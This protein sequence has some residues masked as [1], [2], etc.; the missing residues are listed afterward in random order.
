MRL[1]KTY[2]F[3][4]VLLLFGCNKKEIGPQQVSDDTFSTSSRSVLIACEGNFGWGNASLSSYNPESK[5]ITNNAFET[6][7]GFP[8]GDV[9]QSITEI[10]NKLYIVVN[11]SSKIVVVDKFTLKYETEI[12]GFTSPRH[13][14]LIA[15]DKAYVTDLYSNKI[16]V[17]NTQSNTIIGNIDVGEWSENL[18]VY[19]TNVFVCQPNSNSILVIDAISNQIIKK[20]TV[21]EGAN[22]IALDKYQKLW[23][24]TSGGYQKE[25]AKLYRINPIDFSIEK[26]L[27]FSDLLISP[28]NLRVD[29]KGEKLFYLNNDVFE[30][31]IAD[32]QLN[33][34]PVVSQ[35]NHLFYGLGIDAF[36]D[37]I[38][39]SDAVDYV[40][41]GWIFRHTNSGVMIDSIQTG[42]IPQHFQFINE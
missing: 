31:N 7:N 6:V 35:R 10:N 4:L 28:S 3:L 38:Y 14:T 9:A 42:I 15:P 39:V 37:E 11:N 22:G 2:H 40:Q 30:F 36:S 21:G 16:S 8:L 33:T 23:I 26:T 12:T 29:S 1:L 20:I 34:I 5:T 32:S 18:L 19:G 27:T 17:I 13:I 25:L 41:K 24:L